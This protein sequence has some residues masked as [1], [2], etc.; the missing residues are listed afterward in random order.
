MVVTGANTDIESGCRLVAAA[1]T[2]SRILARTH[3]KNAGIFYLTRV[4]AYDFERLVTRPLTPDQCS[5]LR[6]ACFGNWLS[7]VFLSLTKNDVLLQADEDAA[8]SLDIAFEYLYCGRGEL[9]TEVS[10]QW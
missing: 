5:T 2:A 8:E 1:N 10:A 4:L 9:E 3:G 7:L 6:D